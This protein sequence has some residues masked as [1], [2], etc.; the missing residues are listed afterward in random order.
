MIITEITIHENII[1]NLSCL[2]IECFVF[3]LI[4][5]TNSILNKTLNSTIIIIISSSS[6]IFYYYYLSR[7]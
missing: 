5:L 4:L 3:Y 2:L 7:W 6:S 1:F